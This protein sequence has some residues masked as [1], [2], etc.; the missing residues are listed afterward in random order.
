MPKGWT[1]KVTTPGS[2]RW[3]DTV[4][5]V[6]LFD[7]A[8]E[9]RDAALETVRQIA[10]VGAAVQISHERPILARLSPGRVR[11]RS[12]MLVARREDD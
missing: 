7:V 10:E 5:C 4:D 9:D 6:Q 11:P 3:K 8:I 2:V 1:V 12:K